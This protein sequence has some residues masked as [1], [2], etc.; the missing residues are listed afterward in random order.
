[1]GNQIISSESLTA[2]LLGMANNMSVTKF[3]YEI[4]PA[5]LDGKNKFAID[6]KELKLLNQQI[7]MNITIQD[8]I[9]PV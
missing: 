2:L 6:K 5:L 9:V 8:Q 4:D 7:E 3:K 1:M